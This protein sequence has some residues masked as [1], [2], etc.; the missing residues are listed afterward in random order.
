MWSRKREQSSEEEIT[1]HLGRD[2]R[3]LSKREHVSEE[4]IIGH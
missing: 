2:N 3:S 1:G 4:K